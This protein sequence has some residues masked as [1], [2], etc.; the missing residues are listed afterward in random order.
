MLLSR[1]GQWWTNLLGLGALSCNRLASAQAQ[2]QGFMQGGGR[3]EG[4]G[5]QQQQQGV[6]RQCRPQF[7]A[8]VAYQAWV[9]VLL[10]LRVAVAV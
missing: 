9:Q 3:G 10:L 1:P 4:Q 6:E 2:V 7:I 8:A 5:E